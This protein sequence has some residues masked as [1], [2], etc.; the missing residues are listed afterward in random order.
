MIKRKQPGYYQGFS[1]LGQRKFWDAATRTVVED[2]L[3]NVPAIR[4]FSAEELPIV[5]AVSERILPQDDRLPEYRIPI[6][7]YMDERLFA[8]RIHG[9]RYE[10]MPSDQEAYRLGLRAIDETARVITSRAFVDLDTLNQDLILKSVHDGTK[11]AAHEIWAKMSIDRFWELLVGD[12]VAA[13]Y[14][15][16]WA[17]DE[18]GFG[19]PAYPRAYTRLEG[20]LPEPWEEN[21]QRY[22][23]A[24][25]PDSISDV[26]EKTGGAGKQSHQGQGGSH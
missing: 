6:V 26:Y 11:L 14:A 5:T 12:C 19:G 21:E 13:Y 24:A 4:F 9:Y 18:V 16:P 22:E 15:H 20:G 23:W 17:W 2:R 1:T 7:N 3:N 25:P 10:D 8:N